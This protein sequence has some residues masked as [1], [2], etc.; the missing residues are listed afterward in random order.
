MKIC[1][2]CGVRIQTQKPYRECPSFERC[3]VNICPLDPDRNLRTYCA[4][5]PETR[6]RVRPTTLREIASEYPA[7]LLP[8]LSNHPKKSIPSKNDTMESGVLGRSEEE[9]G[10]GSPMV[11]PPLKNEVAE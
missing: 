8:W 10:S 2:T 6:C 11:A 1:K 4:E 7:E 9:G 5:D 3:S